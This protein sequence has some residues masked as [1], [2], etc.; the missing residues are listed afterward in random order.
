MG[1]YFANVMGVQYPTI[2][3]SIAPCYSGHL[4]TDQY[5]NYAQYPTMRTDIPMPVW[6]C[7][8]GDEPT[9]AFP[10]D[11]EAA[12]KFWRVTVNKLRGCGY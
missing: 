12:R 5:T 2:F 8:G 1:S 4:S 9:S 11:Q 10:G 7:H 6:Q 3:A